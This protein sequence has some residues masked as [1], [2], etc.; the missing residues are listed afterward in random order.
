MVA[1]Q[2]QEPAK[3]C[4]GARL[5]EESETLLFEVEGLFSQVNS[6]ACRFRRFYVVCIWGFTK[7]G[8]RIIRE[9]YYLE[10]NLGFPHF[11]IP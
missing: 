2:D 10:V 3:Q 4:E 1:A 9:S 7:F 5:T 6:R 11:R 8:D